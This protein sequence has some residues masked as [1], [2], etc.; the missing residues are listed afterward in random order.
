M[1]SSRS[2]IADN[3]FAVHALLAY[4][5]SVLL[6]IFLGVRLQ[7]YDQN[8]G[9]ILTEIALIALPALIVLRIHRGNSN[10]TYLRCPMRAS[11][12]GLLLL[13]VALW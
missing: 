3:A 5:L 12:F 6:I 13:A 7:A 2:D 1:A 11:R 8:V 10:E 4:A 9:M